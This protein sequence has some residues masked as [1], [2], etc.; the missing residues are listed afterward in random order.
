M[1]LQILASSSA[2]LME[3]YGLWAQKKRR[4]IHRKK[5]RE[6]NPQKAEEWMR[7]G[8]CGRPRRVCV[9][10]RERMEASTAFKVKYKIERKTDTFQR[11]NERHRQC[12]QRGL[13]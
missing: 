10:Q 9:T 3:S 13:R 7:I 12:R 4:M 6:E 8:V 1:L 5:A 2:M 11:G